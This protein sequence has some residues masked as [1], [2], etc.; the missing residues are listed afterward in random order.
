MKECIQILQFHSLVTFVGPISY[1]G[2]AIKY[3]ID[4]VCPLKV[5]NDDVS[6]H[7]YVYYLSSNHSNHQMI[8]YCSLL[9][10]VNC[11]NN[12]IF[13]CCSMCTAKNDMS[14]LLDLLPLFEQI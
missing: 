11:T 6:I 10:L 7:F 5:D 12:D 4:V 1:V 13:S 2:R 8:S 14:C 9:G 3:P